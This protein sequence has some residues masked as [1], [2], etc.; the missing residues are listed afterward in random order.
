M[1]YTSCI[2][3]FVSIGLVRVQLN[4]KGVAEECSLQQPPLHLRSYS[5]VRMYWLSVAL[6]NSWRPD[7]FGRGFSL[8]SA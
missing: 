3:S 8:F 5:A 6:S 7:L 1:D 2:N 4:K